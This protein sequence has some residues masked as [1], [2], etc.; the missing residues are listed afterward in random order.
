[1]SSIRRDEE[2]V[3]RIRSEDDLQSYADTLSGHGSQHEAVIEVD[4]DDDLT[5]LR[6]KLESIRAPRAILVLPGNAKVLREGLEFRVMR[7]LQR[8]LG[9]DIV[10]V[11]NDLH[12]RALAQEN[13]FRSIFNSL[14]AYYTSRSTP[15]PVSEGISFNDPEEFTPAF[16]VGRWGVLVGGIMAGVLAVIAYLAMPVATVVVY[17]ETQI[18]ARDVQV[19]VEIGGPR[20]DV[21]SQRLSG[22]P[23]QEIVRVEGTVNVRDVNPPPS[24]EPG[25]SG[26]PGFDSSSAVTLDVRDALRNKLLSQASAQANERLRQQLR[27]TE[28]MP[29]A[30][31]R[32]QVTSERYDR[33][34]GDPAETLGGSLEIRATGLAFDNN[35]FNRLVL[36]LWS[37]DVPRDYRS[38]GDVNLTPPEVVAAEGQHMTLR[39]RASGRLVREVDSEAIAAAVR[40]SLLS[41]AQEQLSQIDG[42]AR[43]AEV[44][45]WPQWA[46]RAYR[47]QVERII[48]DPMPPQQP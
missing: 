24:P 11:S 35:D 44:S 48:E 28:S 26:S 47:I 32:I 10:F 29:D 40:G 7:R 25:G 16:S 43:P 36:G 33:N 22:Q 27:S 41:S 45:L 6:S 18:M 37:Q 30:S 38:M 39:V 2:D 20:I 31:V 46:S 19:L 4:R 9:L 21:T 8:E 13:G 1:M 17:P 34:I 12:R 15:A 3:I 42:L 5:S 14:R 23:V